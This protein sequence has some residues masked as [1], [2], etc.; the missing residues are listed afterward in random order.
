[1][2]S[3]DEFK[4]TD[5]GNPP[6]AIIGAGPAGLAAALHLS[7]LGKKPIVFESADKPGGLARTE[8]HQ[9]YRFDLGGHR[10]FTRMENIHQVW[11]EMLG[12]DFLKVKRRSSIFYKQRY[13]HYPLN[14]INTLVNLGPVESFLMLWSYLAIKIKPFPEEN[15]F[16]EWVSNRFGRRLYET[17]FKSYTEKIWGM[18][19]SQIQAH[20]ASQRIKGLSF[21]TAVTNALFGSQQSKTLIDSFHYPRLGP[22]MLWHN[23][24]SAVRKNGGDIVYNAEVRRICHTKNRVT[25]I[26]VTTDTQDTKIPVSHLISSCPISS[27]VYMLTP[28]P[29]VPVV[30]AAQHLSYR[31]F[32][33]VLLIVDKPHLFP[34]QWIYIHNPDVQVGR[35]QNFKNWSREMVPRPDHTSIGMEYFCNQNDVFW[36]KSDDD[37]KKLATAELEKLNLALRG[38]ILE[39]L[40]IRQPDAYPVYDG[41]YGTHLRTIRDYLETIENVQTI[42]RNGM[43]RYNNMDHAMQSGVLAAE[44][45]L[46]ARHNV[47]EINEE[48]DYLEA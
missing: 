36:N 5:P 32:V 44:N 47:W 22:A 10:F 45:A 31:S 48:D 42:G 28:N 43:H 17:F 41:D 37:L 46:G 33:I 7:R 11:C 25:G 30:T 40:V 2:S 29:P 16:E 34:D 12:K 15:S 24:E 13:F 38:D 18:P 26:S 23:I 4:K 21:L 3:L 39:G 14:I 8:I 20:W 27:V 6:I 35:I 19:C 1:M 9:G